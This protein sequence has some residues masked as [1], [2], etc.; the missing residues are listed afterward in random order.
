[1]QGVRIP[2]AILKI[3]IYIYIYI[4]N[5]FSP[6]F[7]YLVVFL[8]CSLGFDERRLLYRLRYTCYYHCT[9]VHDVR[10]FSSDTESEALAVTRWQHGNDVWAM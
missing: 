3:Y 4:E 6:N 9:N 8:K 10:A 5:G 7:I 1:M 2:S